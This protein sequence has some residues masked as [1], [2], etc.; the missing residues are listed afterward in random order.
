M[1]TKN[2]YAKSKFFKQTMSI[3]IAARNILLS[4]IYFRKEI[5]NFYG[6]N[7]RVSNSTR[8]F[9]DYI[10]NFFDECF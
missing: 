10:G 6:H 4:K 8:I 2:Y 9:E 7:K 5:F 1:L 3:A